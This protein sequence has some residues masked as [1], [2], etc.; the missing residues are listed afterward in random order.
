MAISQNDNFDSA[1]IIFVLISPDLVASERWS[2]A[3]T[4]LEERT[5]HV[6]PILA[7]PVDDLGAFSG[8][9]PLPQNR[10]PITKWGNRDE[11]FASIASGVRKLVDQY[12]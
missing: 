4:L 12:D 5:P 1:D 9:E 3:L 11:A 10:K 7:R 8:I 6:I 2:L